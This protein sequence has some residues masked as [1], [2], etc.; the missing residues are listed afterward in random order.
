MKAGQLSRPGEPGDVLELADV[1][2]PR[3]ENPHHGSVSR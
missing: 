1:P 2:R 3:V